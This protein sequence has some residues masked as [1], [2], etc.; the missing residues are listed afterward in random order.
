MNKEQLD[1]YTID[2]GYLDFLRGYEEKVPNQD[3]KI[4]KKFFCGVV[5]DI[6][7]V[8]YFAPISHTTEKTQTGIIITHDGEDKSSIKFCFMVPVPDK[9]IIYKDFAT[10]TEINY[11]RDKY[12]DSCNG[13]EKLA[14]EKALKYVALLNIEHKFCN[15]NIEKIKKKALKVYKIGCNDRHPLNK[16][17][18]D[19]KKLEEVKDMYNQ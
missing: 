5:L 2:E 14:M 19:F 9:Y 8:K 11:V 6:N 18:C 4:N 10:E 7:G 1:F 16:C 15:N 17:C 3:Y 13:D 12:L